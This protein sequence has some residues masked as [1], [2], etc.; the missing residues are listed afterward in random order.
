MMMMMMMMMNITS[1]CCNITIPLRIYKISSLCGQKLSASGWHR[2]R[3]LTRGSA[4]DPAR[5]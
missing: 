3:T 5:G 2:P 1:R 4:L